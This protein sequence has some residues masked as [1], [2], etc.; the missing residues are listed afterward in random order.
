M[1]TAVTEITRAAGASTAD[2]HIRVFA[3]DFGAV[4]RG[5][6][7][8]ATTDSAMSRY[9]RGRLALQDRSGRPLP[10][11]W[12]GARQD[13]DVFLLSLEAPTP[14]GLKGAR[15]FTGLL[16]ERFPDQINI[17]RATL[18]WSPGHAV[19]HRRRRRQAAA[20][21]GLAACGALP[22]ACRISVERQRRAHPSRSSFRQWLMPDPAPSPPAPA[23]SDLIAKAA[24]GDE[25]AIA[26]LYDRFG[27]VLYAVAYRIVGQRA[28]AE[29]VVIEAS[30]RCGARRRGSSPCAD[31][32]PDGSR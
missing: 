23:D 6:P 31:R 3:D 15:V 1:H 13:G 10:L 5:T 29:E 12:I 24:A 26:S 11:R 2:I 17:V 19:V 14:D 22:P 27:G 21:T 18:R 7:G 16:F 20:M 8:A 28:D 30:R 32:W 25:R 9:V 4:V